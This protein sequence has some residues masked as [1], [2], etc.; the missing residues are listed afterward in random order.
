MLENIPILEENISFEVLGLKN[1]QS[2]VIVRNY[3]QKCFKK[4]FLDRKNVDF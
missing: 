4:R 2:L 3:L 1:L